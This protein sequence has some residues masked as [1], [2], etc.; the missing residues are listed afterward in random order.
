MPLS[1]QETKQALFQRLL[2][3][4]DYSLQASYFT[5]KQCTTIDKAINAAFLPRLRINR[6]T[7][8]DVIYGPGKYG[9]LELPDCHTRQTQHHIK[10]M[11]KHLRWNQTVGGDIITTLD[12]IQLAS[13]FVTPILE[14]TDPPIDY[15]DNGW[16]LDLRCRLHKIGATMWIEDAWQPKLQREGDYSLME[17]FLLVHSTPSERK[18]LRAVLHWL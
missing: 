18:S 7:K 14:K 12:N 11:L 16:I 8:R 13:G 15:I 2:P 5:E 3:K 10:Y 9:G 1:E 6:N 4:L 17:R